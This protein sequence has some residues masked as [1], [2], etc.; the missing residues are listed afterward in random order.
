M[1]GAGGRRAP[2]AR[3][4][5][6]STPTAILD[7]LRALARPVIVGGALVSVFW[8]SGSKLGNLIDRLRREKLPLELE[9]G[10]ESAQRSCLTDEEAEALINQKAPELVST[11]IE[12]LQAEHTGELGQPERQAHDVIERLLRKLAT[13]RFARTS[14]RSTH[15]STAA[16]S[17]PS[18][19]C[20]KLQ[21]ARRE[22]PSRPTSRRSRTTSVRGSSSG[23]RVCRSRNGSDTCSNRVSLTSAP[24]SATT[25]PPWAPA[26]SPI[27]RGSA[28]HGRVSNACALAWR[29]VPEGVRQRRT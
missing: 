2:G 4:V 20:A 21:T 25:S 6:A 7:Y 26:F 14:S 29:P 13:P 9:V 10:L 8:R 24:T 3:A 12:S 11:T 27:S 15:A 5:I 28:M 23:Y 16:R 17:P 22:H 18:R 1:W 19:R